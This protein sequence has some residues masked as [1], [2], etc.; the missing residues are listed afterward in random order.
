MP[1]AL[2][3]LRFL[4]RHAERHPAVERVEEAET[5]EQGDR[6]DCSG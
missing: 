4:H 2:I 1:V 3:F 5:G 6:L